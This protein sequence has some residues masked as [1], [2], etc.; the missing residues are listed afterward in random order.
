MASRP[1]ALDDLPA[2]GLL[3]D[4]VEAGSFSRAAQ[5]R[6]LTTSAVSKRV[7]QLEARLGLALLI[8][9][10]RHLS[11][12]DAGQRVLARAARVL[13]D[14]ADTERE[15][16]E[17]AVAP[18]GILRVAT[19]VGLGQSHV[20][21]IVSEF[22]DRHPDVTV[23]LAIDERIVDLVSGRFDLAV[24]CG[25]LRDS[26][27][28]LRKIVPTQRVLCASPEYLAKHGTPAR[29]EDLGAHR[30]LRHVLEDGGRVWRFDAVEPNGGAKAKGPRDVAEVRIAGRFH[31]D[32]PLV[33][34][35]AAVGGAGIAFLPSF[36][37]AD[38]LRAGRLDRVLPS[39]AAERGWVYLA[40]P[41]ARPSKLARAFGDLVAR[42][43]SAALVAG[44]S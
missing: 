10:T 27:L 17:L 15:L 21:R 16:S 18:R 11:A 40:F 8:R 30:C 28:L 23:E 43:V 25:T 34:R 1:T 20:G 3:L 32:N 5:K 42:R 29:P 37:V 35:D 19:S 6:G 36:V 12:T 14:L 38:D 39:L 9:N 31:A 26:N 41:S 13:G 2:L 24:R 22:V 44:P 4:V 7:S 33:L